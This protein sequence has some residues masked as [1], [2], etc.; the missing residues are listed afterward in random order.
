MVGHSSERPVASLYPDGA[1]K[2]GSISVRIVS[3]WIELLAHFF[4]AI[5]TCVWERSGRKDGFLLIL[6]WGFS[7]GF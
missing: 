4:Q 7:Y 1:T 3:F 5:H 6:A 2:S